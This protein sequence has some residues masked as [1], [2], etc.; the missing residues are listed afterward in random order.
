[1][2]QMLDG[3]DMHIFKLNHIKNIYKLFLNIAHK[4]W[5]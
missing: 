3:V 4:S 5:K 1:V 2:E